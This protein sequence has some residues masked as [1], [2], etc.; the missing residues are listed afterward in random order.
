MEHQKNEMKADPGMRAG[1]AK[2]M[3]SA[4]PFMISLSAGILMLVS[5]V[6]IFYSNF[7]FLT[8]NPS[9]LASLEAGMNSTVVQEVQILANATEYMKT[10]FLLFLPIIGISAVLLVYASLLLR[11]RTKK[12]KLMGGLLSTVFSVS[13]FFALFLLIPTFPVAIATLIGYFGTLGWQM[14]SSFILFML[15]SLLGFFNGLAVLYHISIE[16]RKDEI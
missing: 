11:K 3:D 7:S 15:G 8:F 9:S 10:A 4:M 6:I 14:T 12:G 2:Y 1:W 5:L 13:T 16:K